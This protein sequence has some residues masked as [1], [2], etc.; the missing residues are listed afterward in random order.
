MHSLD[1]LL[2]PVSP[3]TFFKDYEG[4]KP[5]HIPAIE[6][7]PKR[8][9]L[10]WRDFNRLLNQTSIWNAQNLRVMRNR[11]S[12][13]P[14]EFCVSRK[15]SAGVISQVSPA[16]LRLLLSTGATVVANEIIHLH[17]PVTHVGAF[18]G[19][20]FGAGVGANVYC[21]F[22]GVKAFGTHF[23]LHDVFAV[24][25]EGEKVWNLYSNRADRPLDCPPDNDSN[26]S[27]FEQTRGPMLAEVRMKPGDV[28]YLPRGWYHDALATDGASVH[29]TFAV[30]P[31]DGRDILL[32]LENAMAQSAVFR[33]WVPSARAEGGRSLTTHLKALADAIDRVLTSQAFRDEMAMTQ[34]KLAPRTT[35]W[36]LPFTYRPTIYRPTGR[37]FPSAATGLK[38]V[39]DWLAAEPGLSVEQILAHVNFV[40]EKELLAGLRAAEIAGAVRKDGA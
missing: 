5:L 17:E 26:R 15:T 27:W 4:R 6:G 37:P 28:L 35:S 40:S 33:D 12:V 10:T 24:Q 11:D 9:L 18:L 8:D 23:D 25:T 22:Q 32:L 2:H 36:D 19:E 7:A 39:Y 1:D 20:A 31:M 16:K 21:S 14:G 34:T 3:A 13:P 29:V 38:I 30:K